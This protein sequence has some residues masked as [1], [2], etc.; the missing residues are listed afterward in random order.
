MHALVVPLGLSSCLLAH[1]VFTPRDPNFDGLAT[2]ALS[3]AASADRSRVLLPLPL[4]PRRRSGPV[5]LA[6]DTLTLQPRTHAV[7][8]FPRDLF[9]L[10]LLPD[11]VQGL[12][13]HP[14]LLQHP[15]QRLLVEGLGLD[16]IL[17]RKVLLNQRL[18]LLKLELIESILVRLPHLLRQAVLCLGL[19]LPLGTESFSRVGTGVDQQAALPLSILLVVILPDLIQVNAQTGI[20][21]QTL[22]PDQPLRLAVQLLD[23][24]PRKVT[25]FQDLHPPSHAVI[26]ETIL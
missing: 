23:Q 9:A 14:K 10:V 5:A 26:H 19:R 1:L 25:G 11:P 21:R 6:A 13:V 17:Q 12:E 7:P 15:H 22:L 4:D 16:G 24:F 2:L 8:R 20:S 18:V 3:F